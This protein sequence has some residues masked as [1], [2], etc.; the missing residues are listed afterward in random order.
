MINARSEKELLKIL[1]MISEESVS[2]SRKSLY[3]T[4]DPYEEEYKS[5]YKMDQKLYGSLSEQEDE[6]DEE[7]EEEEEEEEEEVEEEEVEEEEVEEEEEE[8]EHEDASEAFGVS[9]DSVITAINA[10]RAGRSLKDASIKQQAS[11]YYDKLDDNE[12]KILLLFL[13]ELSKILSGSLKGAEAAEPSDD[14]Y[15]FSI[16]SG[17]DDIDV[18]EDEEEEDIDL[19]DEEEDLEVEEEEED[20]EEEEI[21]P[22]IQVSE[23]KT[24]SLMRKKIRKMMLRG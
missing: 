21:S 11:A 20:E 17:D 22:P 16:S 7:V 8:E 3:E 19:G 9:F 23:S 18:G 24:T 15:E 5:K 14:P 10:L 12:R 2:L 6:E 4:I 13:K 1:K